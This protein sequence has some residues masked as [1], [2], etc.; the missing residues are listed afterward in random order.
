[1]WQIGRERGR[2]QPILGPFP[3]VCLGHVTLPLWASVSSYMKWEQFVPQVGV[4]RVGCGCGIGTVGHKGISAGLP[5]C[6]EV[7]EC[8]RP[9]I[10]SYLPVVTQEAG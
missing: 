4:K 2:G 7:E 5:P 1:M 9:E 8:S 10:D 3:R 6:W